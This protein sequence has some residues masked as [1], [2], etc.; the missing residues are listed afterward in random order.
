[1]LT[2]KSNLMGQDGSFGSVW[3]LLLFSI[4]WV[5][6]TKTG[7]SCAL[8]FYH[9]IS[10]DYILA[11]ILFCISNFCILLLLFMLLLLLVLILRMVILLLLVL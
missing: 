4:R 7:D 1:M 6:L 3:L 5:T 10:C 11:S 9:R 8:R 2:L